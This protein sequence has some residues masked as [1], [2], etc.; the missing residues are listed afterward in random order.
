MFRHLVLVFGLLLPDRGSGA[1]PTRT[2]LNSWNEDKHEMIETRNLSSE[3][4]A[5]HQQATNRRFPESESNVL[6]F[7]IYM[8]AHFLISEYEIYLEKACDT[9]ISLRYFSSV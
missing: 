6:Q 8:V 1:Q 9:H 7:L 3:S 5:K 4:R 2:P